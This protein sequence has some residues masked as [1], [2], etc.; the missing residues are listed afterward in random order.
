LNNT[1]GSFPIRRK[2][3]EGLSSFKPNCSTPAKSRVLYVIIL[4]HPAL[5]ASSNTI[6]TLSS[7]EQKI[8]RVF[9]APYKFGNC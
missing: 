2:N 4:S 5:T 1:H 3:S 8:R 7:E 9:N 6:S